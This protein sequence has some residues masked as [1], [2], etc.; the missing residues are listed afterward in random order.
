MFN[1]F[2]RW[3]SIEKFS[4]VF[5]HARRSGAGKVLLQPKIKLHGTNAAIRITPTGEVTAQK[6]TSDITPENDNAGFARW[7]AGLEAPFNFL[8]DTIIIDGEWAGPGV[9]KGDAV[10]GIERKMFFPFAVRMFD[11]DGTRKGVVTSPI[12]VASIVRATYGD[13]PDMKVLP[14]FCEAKEVNF[15]DQDSCQEFID[16][17]TAEVDKIGENDPFIKEAFG[18][19][20]PGE[21][22]VFYNVSPDVPG[23]SR[24]M[25]KVKTEAHTVQKAKKRNHVAPEKPEGVDEF[26]EMFFT[27]NRFRQILNE[28]FDGVADRKNTGPFIKEMMS[29]VHKESA[30]EIEAADFDWKTVAKYGPVFVK[31]WFFKECDKL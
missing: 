15:L 6:R 1:D 13:N 9:Q 31:N 16:W 3:P 10:A 14:W 19:E 26:I 25:F 18:V 29:D 22:L 12:D 20:G 7:V 21:G 4:D 27:E 2:T 8:E 17:A 23:F 11:S 30:N 24:W 5:Q 28:K